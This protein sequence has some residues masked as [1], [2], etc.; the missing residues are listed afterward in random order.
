MHLHAHLLDSQMDGYVACKQIRAVEAAG[1]LTR[2][3]HTHEWKESPSEIRQLDFVCMLSQL[4]N[5]NLASNMPNVN[6][7]AAAC[8]N[9][10]GKLLLEWKI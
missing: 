1:R 3:R 2:S 8:D 6:E 7:T 5:D 10:F 9:E 4:G